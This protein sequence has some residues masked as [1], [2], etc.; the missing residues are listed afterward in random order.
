MQ[1]ASPEFSRLL[2]SA[3]NSRA[4]SRL[5]V[6]AANDLRRRLEKITSWDSA[7]NDLRE[8]IRE[9]LPNVVLSD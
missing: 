9:A 8:W 5:S 3:V 4:F 6:L 1:R 7:P 2:A